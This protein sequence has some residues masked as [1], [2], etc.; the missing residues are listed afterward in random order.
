MDVMHCITLAVMHYTEMQLH[1][2][3]Y[4]VQLFRVGVLDHA[5]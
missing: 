2:Y 4:G 1:V 5:T 3:R